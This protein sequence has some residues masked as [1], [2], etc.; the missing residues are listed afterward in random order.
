M[1]FPRW[2]DRAEVASNKAPE[3]TENTNTNRNTNMDANECTNTFPRLNWESR[4]GG[5]V[6]ECRQGNWQGC[7][8]RN[9]NNLLYFASCT[10]TMG[11]NVYF[12]NEHYTLTMIISILGIPTTCCTLA[13]GSCILAIG[14][15]LLHVALYFGNWHCTLTI[16][17]VIWHLAPFLGDASIYWVCIFISQSH[18]S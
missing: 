18:I 17:T 8:P 7:H 2:E 11:N 9:T 14:T 3:S 16:G 15:V 10:L 13:I 12:D 1:T 4:A 5:V 6:A